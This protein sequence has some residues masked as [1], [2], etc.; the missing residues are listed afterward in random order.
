MSRKAKNISASLFWFGFVQCVLLCSSE[1][2]DVA[3]VKD[4]VR[5]IDRLGVLGRGPHLSW[6][7]LLPRSLLF[8]CP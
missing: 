5:E 1:R 2:E 3:V 6:E 7:M 4:V 8:L